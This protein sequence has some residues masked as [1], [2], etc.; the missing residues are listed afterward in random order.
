M[1]QQEDYR[2]GFR[3]GHESVKGNHV[4]PPQAPAMTAPTSAENA[5]QQGIRRGIEAAKR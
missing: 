4:H 2:E 3:Q 1:S 5:F